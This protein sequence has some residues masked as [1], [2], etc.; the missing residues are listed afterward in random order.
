MPRLINPFQDWKFLHAVERWHDLRQ[1]IRIPHDP[2]PPSH[3]QHLW[4][5]YM[6]LAF[7]GRVWPMRDYMSG[8]AK[9]VHLTEAFR[10]ARTYFYEKKIDEF[11]PHGR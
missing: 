10:R 7:G 3:G 11:D 5:A 9:T 6:F 2:Q 8:K 4:C 1:S